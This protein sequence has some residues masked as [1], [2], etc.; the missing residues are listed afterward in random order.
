MTKKE[1]FALVATKSTWG[2]KEINRIITDIGGYASNHPLYVKQLTVGDMYF[3]ERI[4]HPGLIVEDRGAMFLVVA[5]TSNPANAATE[6]NTR[7]AH[8]QYA[9]PTIT[10]TSI[11]GMEQKY[12]GSVTLEEAKRVKLAVFDF[13]RKTQAPD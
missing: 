13:I 12:I 3:D 4:N 11:E 8:P 7:Y 10:V 6:V 2:K 1:A 9:Y 5:L